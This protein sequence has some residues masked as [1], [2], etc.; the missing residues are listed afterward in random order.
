MLSPEPRR[1]DEQPALGPA[2]VLI[3]GERLLEGSSLI[4][5]A[6]ELPNQLWQIDAAHWS[7]AGARSVEISYHNAWRVGP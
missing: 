7:L 6:A 5:F 1:A 4:R 2:E 3:S